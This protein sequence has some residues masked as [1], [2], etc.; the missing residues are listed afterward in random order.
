MRHIMCYNAPLVPSVQ[1]TVPHLTYHNVGMMRARLSNQEVHD[2][3][4][5]WILE[6]KRKGKKV[7]FV[8]FGS[9]SSEL[10]KHIPHFVN[11]IED[12]CD[13]L[14]IYA[15]FHDDITNGRLANAFTSNRVWKQLSFVPYPHLVKLVSLVLFTGSVCLQNECWINKCRMLYMPY[16]PEQFLWAKLYKKHTNVN[17]I[18]YQSNIEFATFIRNVKSAL[19]LKPT[20]FQN[21]KKSV[22]K[23]VSKHIAQIVCMPMIASTKVKK[24]IKPRRRHLRSRLLPTQTLLHTRKIYT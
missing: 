6:K 18:D 12:T 1:Y 20:F 15:I 9:Y 24:S 16:V 23:N 22:S 19:H 3:L 8:S 10:L 17:Y 21:V 4:K 5:Q 7:M 13:I 14:D 11:M 2:D